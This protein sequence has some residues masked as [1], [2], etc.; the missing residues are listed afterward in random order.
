MLFGL[1]RDPADRGTLSELL[2]GAGMPV[3]PFRLSGGARVEA[4]PDGG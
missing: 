3:M 1:L 2:A 4:V